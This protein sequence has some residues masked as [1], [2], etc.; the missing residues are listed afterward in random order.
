MPRPRRACLPPR[1]N[2]M[3]RGGQAREDR[4]TVALIAFDAASCNCHA[5]STCSVIPPKEGAIPHTLLRVSP[6]RRRVSRCLARSRS[7]TSVSCFSCT[8]ASRAPEAGELLAIT[9]TQSAAGFLT[10][11]DISLGPAR[12]QLRARDGQRPQRQSCWQPHQVTK[13]EGALRTFSS[14]LRTLSYAGNGSIPPQTDAARGA[15]P[16]DA[17]TSIP[18]ALF[19]GL[20]GEA[21]QKAPPRHWHVY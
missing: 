13:Y 14:A 12:H 16:G 17:G 1:Q 10:A 7:C 2:V 20:I 8:S 11:A 5:L 9:A 18:P 3:L 19:R 21:P 4:A 15:P 6:G